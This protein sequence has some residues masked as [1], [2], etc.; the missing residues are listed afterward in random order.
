MG[1]NMGSNMRSLAFADQG[2]M[3]P[4][5]AVL[6]GAV[7][8]VQALQVGQCMTGYQ[9]SGARGEIGSSRTTVRVPVGGQLDRAR[10]SLSR[11]A[12]RSVWFTGSLGKG[13]ELPGLN[14]TLAS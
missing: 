3:H 13:F 12:R 5:S 9:T 1:S 2:V 6:F 7:Q 4:P 8:Q 10:R 11:A 14:V